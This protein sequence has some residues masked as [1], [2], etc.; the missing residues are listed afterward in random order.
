MIIWTTYPA[1]KA[2][3]LQAVCSDIQL[4]KQDA[5]YKRG[6]GNILPRSALRRAGKS[7]EDVAVHFRKMLMEKCRNRIADQRAARRSSAELSARRR[8]APPAG[9]VIAYPFL[10]CNF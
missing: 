6:N 7:C 10:T 2:R 9:C 3:T 4:S 5:D 8:F 1:E